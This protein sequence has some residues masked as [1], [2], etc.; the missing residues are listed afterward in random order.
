MATRSNIGMITKERKVV[1]AYCHWDG[2]LR[3]NGQILLENYK[4]GGQVYDLVS[5]GSI[6]LLGESI[7]E[8]RYFDDGIDV[9]WYNS[10][11]EYI[12]SVKDDIFIEYIYL[13]DCALK[14]WVYK[15]I[16][17]VGFK[18]LT[19]DAIEMEGC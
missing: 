16:G 7:D 9:D 3:H 17:D 1:V 11:D 6:S 4:N 18:E 12:D 10:L 2:Y 15:Q 13:W 19:Q 5:R 14:C 8:T